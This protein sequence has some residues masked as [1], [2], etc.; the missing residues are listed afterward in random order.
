MYLTWQNM[1]EDLVEVS[2][3]A[4]VEGPDTVLAGE[5][6]PAYVTEYLRFGK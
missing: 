5:D 2:K 3:G 6:R 1:L 4:A